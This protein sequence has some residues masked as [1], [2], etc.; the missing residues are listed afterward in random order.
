MKFP[1]RVKVNLRHGDTLGALVGDPNKECEI[2]IAA[3]NSSVKFLADGQNRNLTN[4]AVRIVEKG[5]VNGCKAYADFDR[6][7]DMDGNPYGHR[8][9]A[10]LKRRA[11]QKT[12]AI[13]DLG[14]K[15]LK[16]CVCLKVKLQVITTNGLPAEDP[17]AQ[18]KFRV[19]LRYWDG[20]THTL[21]ADYTPRYGSGPHRFIVK[22]KKEDV[23]IR[24]DNHEAVLKTIEELMP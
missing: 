13:I 16:P 11:R 3:V 24:F 19:Q 8:I 10:E 12:A 23:K 4:I 5:P 20:R 22:I 18:P 9:K 21:W 17:E 15:S 7:T 14:V 2:S 1:K 6:I